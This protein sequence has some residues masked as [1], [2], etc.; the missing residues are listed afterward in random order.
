M[1]NTLTLGLLGSIT[2]T[3]I[4]GMAIAQNT[5]TNLNVQESSNSAVVVG[6]GN[7]V[8]QKN[9]QSNIQHNFNSGRL[10]SVQQSHNEAAVIGNDNKIYQNS[11]QQ[12]IQ[13][14]YRLNSHNVYHPYLNR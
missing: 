12:N 2:I 9:N 1:K 13:E 14:R 8:N 11:Q 5:N 3:L 6:S 4:P 10:Q 7:T